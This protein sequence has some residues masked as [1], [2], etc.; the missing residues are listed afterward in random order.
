MT[1]GTPATSAPNIAGKIMVSI[2]GDVGRIPLQLLGHIAAELT[3]RPDQ[4]P[5]PDPPPLGQRIA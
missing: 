3:G 5:I 2:N 4:L 1:T